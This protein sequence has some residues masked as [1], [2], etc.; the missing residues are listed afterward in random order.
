MTSPFAAFGRVAPGRPGMGRAMP[1]MP[2]AAQP[3]LNM[4][5][6]RNMYQSIAHSA[7][8]MQMIQQMNIPKE[9]QNNPRGLIQKLMDD[10]R[11]SQDQ[12]NQ[13]VQKAG[14]IQKMLGM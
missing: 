6:L 2:P 11:L 10:G 3:G 4:Q 12:Y 5:Q 14:V 9:F 13:A 8:P 7:N 1:S